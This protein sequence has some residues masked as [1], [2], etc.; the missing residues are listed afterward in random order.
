MTH[1]MSSRIMARRL[2]KAFDKQ[3]LLFSTVCSEGAD[4]DMQRGHWKPHPDVMFHKSLTLTV[5]F[6]ERSTK[7]E[8]ELSEDI[9]AH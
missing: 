2:M 3:S 8:K 5:R 6:P 4:L 7:P 9:C 1:F